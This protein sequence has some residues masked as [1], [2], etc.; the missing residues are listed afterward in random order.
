[1]IAAPMSNPIASRAAPPPRINGSI[2]CC[3]AFLRLRL[4]PDLAPERAPERGEDGVSTISGTSRCGRL[5]PSGDVGFSL[6]GWV[7]ALGG[8]IGAASGARDTMVA[9]FC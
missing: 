8:A 3:L 6:I 7:S 1:M 9:A 4:E 2:D 5:R